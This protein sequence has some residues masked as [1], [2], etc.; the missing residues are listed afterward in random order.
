MLTTFRNVL[1]NVLE[2]YPEKNLSIG[3]ICSLTDKKSYIPTVFQ[4][5]VKTNN[6]LREELKDLVITN[7]NMQGV[8]ISASTV[9]T[10]TEDNFRTYCTDKEYWVSAN[11]VADTLVVEME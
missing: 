3:T 2:R 9:R 6:M 11:K 4:S 7:K 5:M 1:G 10:E 8:C